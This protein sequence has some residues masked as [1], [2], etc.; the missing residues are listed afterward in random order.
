MQERAG[1]LQAL[2]DR[3]ANNVK[4]FLVTQGIAESRIATKAYGKERPVCQE[5]SPDEA[6]HQKNRR[7]AFK[8][9]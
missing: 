4:Q 8:Q 2:S 9:Q 5:A 6:C 3:R 7:A 1:Y